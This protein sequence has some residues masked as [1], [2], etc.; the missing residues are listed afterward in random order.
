MKYPYSFVVVVVFN[1][2]IGILQVLLRFRDMLLKLTVHAHSCNTH[3]KE[4]LFFFPYN[5]R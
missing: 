4:S 1:Y 3:N 5:H 2:Y